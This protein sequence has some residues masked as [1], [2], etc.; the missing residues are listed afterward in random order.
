MNL[1]SPWVFTMIASATAIFSQVRGLFF[2]FFTFFMANVE[3]NEMYGSSAYMDRVWRNYKQIPVGTKVYGADEKYI[4]PISRHGYV[5]HEVA[6]KS[7]VYIYNKALIF[8]SYEKTDQNGHDFKIKVSYIRWLYDF[9]SEYILSLA[10]FNEKNFKKENNRKNRFR[11]ER[12]YGLRRDNSESPEY[13]GKAIGPNN[14]VYKIIGY[15][16]DDIGMPSVSNPF[17]FLS[18]DKEIDDLVLRLKQWK[19]SEAWCK[20]RMIPWRLSV[21]PYGKPGTGK[22]SFVKAIAQELDMPIFIFD[23]TSMDNEDLVGAW[24]RAKSS[25]PAIILFE[26]FDRL[27]DENG[28][29]IIKNNTSKSGVTMDCILN[30]MSGVE[31]AD[32]ILTFLTANEISKIDPAFGVVEASGVSSRPGRIDI[33][34]KFDVLSEESRRNVAKR[35]LDGFDERIEE[36][37]LSGNGETGAQ[38]AKRCS[39]LAQQLFWKNFEKEKNIQ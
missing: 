32:G 1:S 30:L 38:F 15:K 28:K 33:F 23:L 37:V 3:I 4:I 5:G 7:S 34:V 14:G 18:Y 17:T 35:I 22:T 16:P 8:I 13:G 24:N 11:I 39:D 29:W 6:G 2:R 31:P 12:Y 36:V 9:Q 10:E 25:V 21:A 19:E 27:F 20:K 26:D